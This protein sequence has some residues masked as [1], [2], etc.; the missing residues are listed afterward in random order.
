LDRLEHLCIEKGMRMTEQRRVIARVLS[1]ASDHPDVE[2]LHRRAHDIDPH[3][4]IATV[5]RTVRLFEESG[6]LTRHDFRDGR[7]AQAPLHQDLRLSDERLRQRAHG[8]C[9]APAGLWA[10]RPGRGRRSGGAQ[11]LPHP[12]KGDREGLFRARPDQGSEGGKAAAGGAMLVAVAGCVAQA[13]G[14]EIMRRQPAVDLVVGPQSY[15]RLPELIARAHRA[16]GEALAADFAPEEKFDALPTARA[17]IRRHRLPHRAGGLRQVLHL[18]RGALYAR[19]R[20]FAARPRRS[21]P[22]P[23]AGGA[24]RARGHPAGPERQRLCDGEGGW[25]RPDPAAGEIRAWIASATPPAT[26]ATWT[27]P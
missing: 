16:A 18:L 25:R 5:Y 13:E 21:W 8:R 22:R 20:I 9:P 14:E 26:R 10:D 3:I 11:H 4:S 15:H 6:I 17:V 27:T 23:G 12:R 1:L 19:R 24:G 2:E 7:S